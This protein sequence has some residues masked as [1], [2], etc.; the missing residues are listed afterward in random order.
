MAVHDRLRQPGR[1][2]AEEHVER[3]VERHGLEGELAA[4]GPLGGDRVLERRQAG[5]DRGDLLAPVDRLA[6][7]RVAVDRDEH[8][9]LDL[10]EAVDHAAR[11]ELRRDAGPDRAE[12]GRGEEADQRLGDVREVGHDAVAAADAEPLQLGAR[13]RDPRAQLAERPLERLARLR[14]RDDASSSAVVRACA[15]RS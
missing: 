12:A 13:A 3:V 9:R 8:L 2:A 7:V 4:R 14:A 11:A 10:R 6:A 15:R 1:A 5:L